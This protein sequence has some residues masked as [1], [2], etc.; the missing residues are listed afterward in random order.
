MNATDL[1]DASICEGIEEG[2]CVMLQ[3]GHIVFAGRI[4][5]CPDTSGCLLLLHA[6]D[7]DL[8]KNHVH[9]KLN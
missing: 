1:F 2:S 8:L 6:N 9:R 7:F 5:H 3:E 4:S